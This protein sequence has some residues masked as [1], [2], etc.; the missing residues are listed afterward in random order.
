MGYHRP[1]PL[2][3][4][5]WTSDPLPAPIEMLTLSRATRG[6]GFSQ[7]IYR[8]GIYRK[9]TS[10]QTEK[11][12]TASSTETH[13]VFNQSR[14]FEDVDYYTSDKPLSTLMDSLLSTS[15]TEGDKERYQS[16]LAEYGK[17]IGSAGMMHLA[18]EANLHKP[19]LHQFDLQ[20]NRVDKTL[21]TSEYHSLMEYGISHHIT[22]YGYQPAYNNNDE[23]EGVK[24]DSYN[25]HLV[26]AGFMYFENQL[27]PGHCCPL[28]M[29]SAAIPVFLK[30]SSKSNNNDGEG[31]NY[32]AST[33]LPKLLSNVYD[34]RDVP[35]D[36]KAGVT[37]GM[38]MTEKQGGS[39][40]RANTTIAT[41]FSSSDGTHHSGDSG[42]FYTLK[43]HK[44]FTSAPMSDGFLTLAK[45]HGMCHSN[46]VHI[47]PTRVMVMMMMMIVY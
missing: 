44:W 34:P 7:L 39:D 29:T 23:D 25:Q 30:A 45:T 40:V 38:S 11:P 27:E 31:S 6:Y 42:S 12:L 13:V 18:R 41:P 22:N 33:W 4:V 37:I 17:Q 28:V 5:S 26:R 14:P 16:Q 20:G 15:T 8:P 21:Y 47:I 2:A 36:E 3:A 32:F 24:Q 9:S 43:G 10:I 19:Q 1:F 46:D 35:V